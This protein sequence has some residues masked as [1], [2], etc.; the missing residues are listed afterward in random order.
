[1]RTILLCLTTGL[2]LTACSAT[3]SIKTTSIDEQNSNPLTA[4]RY[5]DR[6]ADALANL[7]IMKHPVTGKPE[8]VA[9]IQTEIAKAKGISADARQRM[10]MGKQ[11]AFIPID[12]DTLG[13]ALML[14]GKLYFS[15]EFDTK[16]GVDVH[17]YLTT[18]ADPRDISFPDKNAVDLGSLQ[19]AYGPQ[20]YAVPTQADAKT[21]RTLVLWERKLKLLYAFVQLAALPQ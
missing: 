8:N 19:A 18:V 15:S 17:V 4:A 14:N 13:Y 20:V 16:P 12:G 10:A 3:Q 6:L 1:M 21:Y 5:G 2:M 9:I 7:I 11:G